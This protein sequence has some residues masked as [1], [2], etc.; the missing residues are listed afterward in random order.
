MIFRR[1]C[2]VPL[3]RFAVNQLWHADATL[4]TL[5]NCCKDSLQTIKIGFLDSTD[6]LKIRRIFSALFKSMRDDIRSSR[7]NRHLWI[8]RDDVLY[9]P[10]DSSEACTDEAFEKFVIEMFKRPGTKVNEC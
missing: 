8:S 3:E 10:V 5:E 9:F 6:S 7:S 2:D 1:S 4:D